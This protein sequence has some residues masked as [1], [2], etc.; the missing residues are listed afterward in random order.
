MAPKTNKDVSAIME[1]GTQVDAALRKGVRDALV[2]HVQAG[3]P[4]VEWR[5]GKCVWIGPEEITRRPRRFTKKRRPPP[6]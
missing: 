4:V 3:A 2:R 5:D 1:E 6:G